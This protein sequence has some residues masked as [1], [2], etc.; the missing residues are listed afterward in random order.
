M[1]LSGATDVAEEAT[2]L[3]EEPHR[4]NSHNRKA[5]RKTVPLHLL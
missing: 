2:Q 3:H 4:E 5:R 1:E